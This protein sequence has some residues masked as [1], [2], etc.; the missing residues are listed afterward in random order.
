MRQRDTQMALVQGNSAGILNSL[1]GWEPSRNK[2][3]RTGPPRFNIGWRNRFFE[4][5][6]GLIKSLKFGLRQ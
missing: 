3:C 5:I 6:L 2:G 4:S 1:W